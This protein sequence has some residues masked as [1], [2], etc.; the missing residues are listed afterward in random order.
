MSTYPSEWED[1]MGKPMIR[2]PLDS[3]L[4]EYNKV[5]N[6]FQASNPDFSQVLKV[7]IFVESLRF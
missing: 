5:F 2:V 1:M 7:N 6:Q 3:H 4:V